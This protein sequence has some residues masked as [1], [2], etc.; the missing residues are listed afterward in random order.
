MTNQT[1]VLPADDLSRTATIVHA[2]DPGLLHLGIGAGTYTV[3]ISGDLTGG[4]YTMLD[5]FVPTGGPPPHRH[6][7][8]EIFHILEG[9]LEITFRDEVHLVGPGQ[10]INI[11]A[12]APHGFR[13][14]SATPA[15]FLCICLPSGQEEYF[16][17]VGE[18][19]PARTT[20]P[21]PPSPEVMTERRSIML[22]NA[23]RFHS[24]FLPPR[25]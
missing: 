12:N 18:V 17:L 8:E 5:M 20:P 6:D 3:V 15:R 1:D 9:E 2:D 23:A 24:E 25:A 13:V 10:I 4:R 21:T 7:F 22:A 16:K 19:L 14:V 11:P